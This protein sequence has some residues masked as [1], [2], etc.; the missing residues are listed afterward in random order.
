M[1]NL[2]QLVTTHK[3]D[4][5]RGNHANFYNKIKEEGFDLDLGDFVEAQRMLVELCQEVITETNVGIAEAYIHYCIR[6]GAERDVAYE[7][8]RSFLRDVRKSGYLPKEARLSLAT[9]G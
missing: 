2:T 6:K 4:I 1:P 8:L 9:L 5:K 3:V 7:S